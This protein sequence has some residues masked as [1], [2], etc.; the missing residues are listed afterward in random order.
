MSDRRIVDAYNRIELGPE[1]AEQIWSRV[2]QELLPGKENE[3]IMKRRKTLRIA[4]IAAVISVLFITSAYAVSGNVRANGSH[5]MKDTGTYDTLDAIPRVEKITGY[6]ITAPEEF[7]NGYRFVTLNIG[8]EAAYGDDYEVLEEYYGVMI[9]YE[10]DGERDLSL[11]LS[12]VLD[13]ISEGDRPEPSETEEI[14]GVEVRF[15]R[16]HFKFVPADY[17]KSESD[18]AAEKE[19]HYYISFGSDSIEE[20]DYTFAGFVLGDVEYL[21]FDQSG[22]DAE[23]LYDMAEEVISAWEAEKK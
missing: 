17:V 5:W 7:G 10:K 1:R 21:L 9:T 16:D 23:F 3:Q 4:L 6:P 2:E 18:L 11:N 14:G 19:S 15:S 12:P 13:L 8:G 22:R 20:Y